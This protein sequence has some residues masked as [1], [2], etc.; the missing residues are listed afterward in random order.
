MFSKLTAATL[1]ASFIALA[2]CAQ[3]EN[4]NGDSQAQSALEAQP[5]ANTAKPA[6]NKAG[7]AAPA[8]D[9]G[10]QA[11]LTNPAIVEFDAQTVE[12]NSDAQAL[13]ARLATNAKRSKK[14][15]ITGYCDKHKTGKAKSIALSR[16]IKVKNELIKNGVAAKTIR[17]KYITDQ[18]KNLAKVDL[19]GE[20]LRVENGAA[21]AHKH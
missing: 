2:G 9:N 19:G 3:M 4:G 10:A 17:V 15:V 12:L 16:A 11:A 5:Q 18:A 20:P 14:I 6:D 1:A 8:A 13:I 7:T 21:A